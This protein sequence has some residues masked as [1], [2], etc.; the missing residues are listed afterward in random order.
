MLLIKAFVW[1]IFHVIESSKEI[2]PHYVYEQQL[3]FQV[4]PDSWT[5]RI[6]ELSNMC[7]F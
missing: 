5:L 7:V 2:R 3:L 1:M 6:H 4:S